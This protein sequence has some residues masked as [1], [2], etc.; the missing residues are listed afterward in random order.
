MNTHPSFQLEQLT[1][2][3]W[4]QVSRIYQLGIDTGI[5]TFEHTVPAEEKF[6]TGKI[7]NLGYVAVTEDQRVLGWIAA[8]PVS[9][10]QAYRGVIEHS[11]YVDPRFSGQGVANLL[12]QKLIEQA[13]LHGYWMIQ[14]SVFSVNHPSLSLH[15]KLGF[16]EVGYRERI[17]QAATG[18]FAGHWMNTTLCELR[19]DH[20][21]PASNSSQH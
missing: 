13:T 12:L 19:L 18:P 7:Q 15:Q 20:L 14:C 21:S 5:A 6:F 2:H 11:V 17:A 4:T 1:T 16:R 9:T 10:R 8:T 3:H